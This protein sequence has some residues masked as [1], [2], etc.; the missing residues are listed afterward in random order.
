M[1]K[2]LFLVLTIVSWLGFGITIP[3]RLSYLNK[4]KMIQRIQKS[5]SADLFGDE[6]IPIGQATM[7]V[8]DDPKAF[9]GGP[10]ANEV[11]KVDEGYLTEHKVYPLQLKTI[12]FIMFWTKVLSLLGAMVGMV[13]LTWINQKAKLTKPR[14]TA[15][16]AP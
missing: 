14:P 3:I 6:G 7:L 10:D 5:T 11:Y 8:I 16:D 4:A 9:I 2:K 1:M 15:S 12:N 13:G